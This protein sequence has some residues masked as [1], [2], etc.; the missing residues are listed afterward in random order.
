MW[1]QLLKLMRPKQWIKNGFVF[2]GYIFSNE[3][4]NPTLLPK[5][6]LTFIAFCFVSSCIYT[7]NDILDCE[8]DRLHPKKK[9][10]PIAAGTVT[11][12]QAYVLSVF[13]GVMGLIIGW[14]VSL[15]VVWILIAYILMNI[16]YTIKLK[17]IVILDVFCISAGFM[18]RIFAGT[19]GIGIPP[20][21][22][23]LLCG[24]S[25][26]L[27][28]G[29][30]KRRAELMTKSAERREVL[31]KYSPTIL[32]QIL[33]ICATSSILAYSLYTMSP[34]TIRLHKTDHL[35]YTVPFVIYALFRYIYLLHKKKKG[36][37]PSQELIKDP[38]IL[39]AVLGWAL[40]T[41]FLIKGSIHGY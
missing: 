21:Q 27:F 33:A 5:A 36:E 24:L 16:L 18:L 39:A 12:S 41:F 22:W 34:D 8:K 30:A 37:D 9:F 20:S 1:K 7:F 28:L 2:T 17:K 32:D 25:I 4:T 13:L 31:E 26:T 23:L 35:I 38:H 29:F 11:L 6:I 14:W 10:R 19:I 40:L 15:A 3:Y